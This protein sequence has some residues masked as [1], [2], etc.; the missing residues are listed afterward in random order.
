LQTSLSKTKTKTR[1]NIKRSKTRY[2]VISYQPSSSY[3]EKTFD[4]DKVLKDISMLTDKDSHDILDRQ[5]HIANKDSIKHRTVTAKT[6]ISHTKQKL[7]KTKTSTKTKT[8]PSK[9]KTVIKDKTK[10]V[11]KTKT[12]TK[13]RQRQRQRQTS[14]I[15]K[16]VTVDKEDKDK[17]SLM[18]QRQSIKDKTL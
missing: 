13:T 12:K 3:K 15:T 2:R 4:K 18:R 5:R 16:T 14:I 7:S 9:T 6:A 11:I 1:Q 10:T 8:K 17:T